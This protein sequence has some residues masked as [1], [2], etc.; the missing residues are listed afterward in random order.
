MKSYIVVIMLIVF[1]I[2]SKSQAFVDEI[3]SRYSGKSGFTS[4]VINPQLFKLFAIIDK[5]DPELKVLS[6]KFNSL[7]ILVSEDKSVGFTNEIR[8]KLKKDE[9]LN[10]MEIIDGSQKVN[11]YA[12]KKGEL[13]TDFLLLSI[14]DKEEVLLSITGNFSLSELSHIGS[15]SSSGGSM[16]HLELL[17]KLEEK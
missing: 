14:D 10:L 1:P 12:K 13:I 2:L 7:K 11:F 17:K 4:V 3:F 8:E 16:A 9:Y 5:E 6:E 15:N